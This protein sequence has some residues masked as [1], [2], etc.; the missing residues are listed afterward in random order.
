MCY[1]LH[2]KCQYCGTEYFCALDNH[3]CPSLNYDPDRLMC[4]DCRTRINRLANELTFNEIRKKYIVKD[5][6]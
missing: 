1:E 3:I 2:H 6:E 4:D 5:N